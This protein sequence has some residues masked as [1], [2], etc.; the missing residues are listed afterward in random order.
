MRISRA[1]AAVLALGALLFTATPVSAGGPTSVLL[2]SPSTGR[3]ASLYATDEA[4]TTLMT[5]LGADQAAAPD[6]RAAPPHIGGDQL[7]VTWMVHDVQPWRVDRIAFDDAGLPEW[8]HTTHAMGAGPIAFDD[9][10]VRHRP[11]D[12]EALAAVLT[13]LGLTGRTGPRPAGEDRREATVAA[14]GAQAAAVAGAAGS[15]D[16]PDDGALDAATW[17]LPAV[18]GGIL[19]GV[20]GDRWLRR[21]RARADD[22]GRWQLVDVPGPQA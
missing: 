8:V 2:V 11:A 9:G 16:P 21:R 3:T 19:A 6:S 12:A 13:D 22:G 15:A 10:G 14:G 20:L 18:A 7:V 1:A 5:Q 17:A 4:Y